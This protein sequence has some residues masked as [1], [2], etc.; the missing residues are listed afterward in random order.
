MFV[1][2]R[3]EATCRGVIPFYREREAEHAVWA[4]GARNVGAGS[5]WVWAQ[6]HL[7]EGMGRQPGEHLTR[8]PHFSSFHF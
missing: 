7:S 5:L 8:L 1:F 2:P 4:W 6:E 3:L